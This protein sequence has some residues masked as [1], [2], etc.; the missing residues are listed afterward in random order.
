M[1]VHPVNLLGSTD[2]DQYQQRYDEVHHFSSQEPC[3]SSPTIT[4]MKTNTSTSEEE[5]DCGEIEHNENDCLEKLGESHLS[6]GVLTM[7]LLSL[8][9]NSRRISGRTTFPQVW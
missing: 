1:S 5:Y 4:L 2:Q 9:R 8:G 6:M 3:L 7:L